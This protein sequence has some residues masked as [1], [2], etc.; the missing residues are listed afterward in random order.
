MVFVPNEKLKQK[1]TKDGSVLKYMYS[2]AGAGLGLIAAGIMLAAI[3]VMLAAALMNV[4][5]LNKVLLIGLSVGIPG[6]VLVIAGIFLQKRRMN[7]WMKTY[8][9]KTGLTEEDIRQADE[10]F[11]QPG[12]VL[13][14]MEKGKDSNSRKKM[15]FIT[16]HYIK[17]PGAAPCLFRLQDLAVCFYTKKFL[18][19]DGGYDYALVAYALDETRAYLAINYNEKACLEIVETVEAHNPLVIT[20]HHFTYEG[21]KYDAVRDMEDVI[22]LQKQVRG[23]QTGKAE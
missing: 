1:M 5:E 15:G 6:I 23:I 12:T 3:G 22:R 18:C 21:K 11:Q 9:K 7:Q 20:A 17:F 2:V 14:A 13:F 10:E 4:L 19:Q 16:A 8:V